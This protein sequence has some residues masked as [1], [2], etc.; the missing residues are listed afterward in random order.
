M[1]KTIKKP[2]PKKAA[3][4]A[5][6]KAGRDPIKKADE[7]KL[8]KAKRLGGVTIP[9]KYTRE[10]VREILTDLLETV[11]ANPNIVFLEELLAH[12][13]HSTSLYT[14]FYEWPDRFPD[15]D[16]IPDT[17]L[18]IRLILKTR[19]KKGS[20]EG[21]YHAA[22]SQFFLRS[23]YGM[24]DGTEPA[25]TAPPTLDQGSSVDATEVEVVDT[26]NL[27]ESFNDH[28]KEITKAKVVDEQ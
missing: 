5:A 28:I 17:V 27:V 18:R 19:I 6:K 4:K 26:P 20:L 12:P 3:P 14:R 23:D 13:D 22:Q 1:A 7:K 25:R 9:T 2:A 10:R 8:S 16:L 11:L 21:K 24:R 15:D